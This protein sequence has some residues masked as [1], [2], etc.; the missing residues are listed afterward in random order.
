MVVEGIV[1]DHEEHLVAL[2]GI[3]YGCRIKDDGD[4]QLDVLDTVA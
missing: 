4:K 1:L 3:L 2:A